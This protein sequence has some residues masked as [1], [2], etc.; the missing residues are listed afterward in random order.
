VGRELV[1]TADSGGPSLKAEFLRE[2]DHPAAKLIEEVRSLLKTRDTF[3]AKHILEHAVGDQV[4][5]TINQTK[6][7][8]GG[9]GTGRLSYTDP[10][11]QQ[12]PSRNKKIAAIVKPCF[13]PDEGDV[14]IDLDQASFEVRMTGRS[15]SNIK[16]IRCWIS[17]RPSPI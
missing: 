17:T 16:R 8:D 2:L 13:L 9:T 12:I 7:E 15:F 6:G 14:W 10:A 1:G 4:Y 3:L 5:P 11:M